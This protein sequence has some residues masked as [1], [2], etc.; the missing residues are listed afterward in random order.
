MSS[1]RAIS[2][3]LVGSAEVIGAIADE[4]GTEELT[5]TV[6]EVSAL[7]ADPSVRWVIWSAAALRPLID[8]GAAVAR[9]WEIAEVHRLRHGGWDA[10]PALIWALHRGLDPASRPPALADDLFSALAGLP[11][12]DEV[13][14]TTGHL[15]PDALTGAWLTTPARHA[16]WAQAAWEV[17]SAQRDAL[18]DPRH[19]AAA[20]AESAAAVLC[21]ELERDGLPID[22]ATMSALITAAAGPL[23][24]DHAAELVHRAERDAP[25]LASVPGVGRLDLRNPAQVRQL[26]SLAGID[27]TDTRRWTLEAH[28]GEHPVIAAL[29]DWRRRE[30]IATTYGWGWLARHVGAD[31]RLRGAWSASDGA[32]GRMTAQA[33][34]HNLPAELRPGVAAPAGSVLIRSDLGQVEPRVLAAVARDDALARA[35]WADDLYAPV[36]ERLGVAREVAKIA[37]LAAMYGQRSGA[38]GDALIGLER[39]YPVAMRHLGAAQEAG[40][41]G[42]SVQTYGGRRVRVAIPSPGEPAPAA[43]ARGRFAR[44]AVIQG[45]AAELFKA[46]AASVRVAVRPLHGR[47][48][49]CLHDELLVEVPAENADQA[50]AAIESTLTE[51]ARWWLRGYPVR[52][53]ADTTIVQ[54]W[55]EAK[56]APRA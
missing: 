38:A 50:A 34:L 53:V 44:N 29:L 18:S 24:R 56:P 51:T 33:G 26:L 25:V 28:R 45:S 22:R 49:L 47:I 2:L 41:E 17:A 42:R 14:M 55:S 15:R 13:L 36:A 43:A 16:A 27:V 3:S 35:T 48:V 11:G 19:L 4:S 46:W 20:H 32:A 8:A 21:V 23:P 40:R 37:V 52:F 39:E 6:P 54:R 30:R 7:L 12:G 1:F 31:D 9:A 10:D 5:A